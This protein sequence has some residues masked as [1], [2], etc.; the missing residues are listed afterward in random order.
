MVYHLIIAKIK[1][2]LKKYLIRSQP[3]KQYN[4][5]V[6][7]NEGKQAIFKLQL[8]NRFHVVQDVGVKNNTIK[9]HWQPLKQAFRAAGEE[10]AMIKDKKHQEWISSEILLEVEKR[11][12]IKKCSEFQQKQ[13]QL[14]K[15]PLIHTV[16]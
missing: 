10:S 15:Q 11:R 16:H 4:G 9:D 12:C 3:G 2:K 7:A 1:L 13:E 8:S 6:L 14:S 5:S